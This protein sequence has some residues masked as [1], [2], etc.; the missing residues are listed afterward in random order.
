MKHKLAVS[1]DWKDKVAARSQCRLV[2]ITRANWWLLNSGVM[3]LINS[4]SRLRPFT[5]IESCECPSVD[6]LLLVDL[7]TR[8][9]IHCGFCRKEVDPERLQLS[10]EETDS[11]AHWF[12][13]SSALYRLWLHSG[14][15]EGY[16]K[17]RLL[18]PQGQINVDGR[19]IAE[20]L[21]AKWPTRLWLFY[22]T[23]DGEPTHCPVCKNPL[24]LDV[25][26]GTGCCDQCRIH[27]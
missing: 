6:S 3:S 8:N 10:V 13:A 18:D 20:T 4:Y 25:K 5:D 16:A 15:Y 17:A 26:W 14:E 7:L 11:I 12:S 9:P 1:A 19:K 23:D 2:S 21:S 27:I 24:N 22:D